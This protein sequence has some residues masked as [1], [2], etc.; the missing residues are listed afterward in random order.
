MQLLVALNKIIQGSFLR[1]M[2]ISTINQIVTSGTNFA[3]SIYLLGK[4]N[5]EIFGQFGVL[6]AISFVIAGFGN[7]VFL[8]QMVVNFPDVAN[9]QRKRYAVSIF[10]LIANF[11]ILFAIISAVLYSIYIL[12][13]S[14][15]ETLWLEILSIYLFSLGFLSKE[16]F[17]RLA[18]TMHRESRALRINI[19]VTI[20]LSISLYIVEVMNYSLEPFLIISCLGLSAMIGAAIG[21]FELQLPLEPNYTVMR[22]SLRQVWV[23]GKWALVNDVFYSGRQQAHIFL[24]VLIAGSS[25]VAMINAAKMFVVPVLILTPS[26]SQLYL[27]RL[28]ALRKEYPLLLLYRGVIF[29]FVNVICVLIY[30]C[31]LYL[32]FDQLLGLLPDND[33]DD[34]GI[35]VLAWVLVAL[36]MALRYGLESTQK[37]LKRFKLLALINFPLTIISMLLVYFFLKEYGPY[38]AIFGLAISEMTLAILLGILITATLKSLKA[39]SL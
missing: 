15:T 31:I 23:G 37:A 4:M 16:F 20:A 13:F 36:S 12:L 1:S 32:L 25:G 29:S 22:E 7:V 5:L 30:G 9:N 27:V 39:P 17:C 34:F 19:T 2:S 35:Y 33:Y 38:G 11:A 14:G 24:T 3:L 10:Y 21:Q 6:Q 18:Y 26:I 28:V 8:G